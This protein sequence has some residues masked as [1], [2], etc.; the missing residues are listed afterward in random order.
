MKFQDH[1]MQG[2]KDVGRIQSV[3]DGRTSPKQYGPTAFF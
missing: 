2:S 1:T 3:R